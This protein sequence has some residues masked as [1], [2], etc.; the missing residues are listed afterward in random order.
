MLCWFSFYLV[1]LV[2]IPAGG[3]AGG[4][5]KSDDGQQVQV[6]FDRGHPRTSVGG[7]G[8]V[9]EPSVGHVAETDQDAAAASAGHVAKKTNKQ[10]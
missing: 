5:A 4:G 3:A 9:S 1:L 6:G 10:Y 2:Y 7:V 8:E